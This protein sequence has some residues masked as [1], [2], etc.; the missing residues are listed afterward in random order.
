MY[1]LEE[2]DTTALIGKYQTLQEL[3]E[4]VFELGQENPYLDGS[5]LFFVYQEGNEE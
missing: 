5:K 2:K 3:V 1:I 4:A